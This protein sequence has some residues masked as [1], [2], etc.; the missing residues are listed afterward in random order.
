MGDVLAE[1]EEVLRSKPTK[2]KIT[3]KEEFVLRTCKEKAIGDFTTGALVSSTVVW[4]ATRNLTLGHR[5]NSSIGSAIVAGMWRFNRSLN[6]CINHV[7]E[8]EGSRMQRE[9]AHI[10]LTKHHDNVAK[11]KLVQKHFYSEEVFG[12]LNPDKPYVR[13]RNRNL[14]YDNL[15]AERPK[16]VED[17]HRHEQPAIP[18]KTG[19]PRRKQFNRSSAAGDLIMDPLDCIFGEVEASKDILHPDYGAAV[20]RRHSRAHKRAHR[21]RRAQHAEAEMSSAITDN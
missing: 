6:S 14:Y 2:E 9:L 4:I 8:L 13:W 5:F 12:D 19:I 7:L 20:E 10:I 17:P 3:A 16:D 21:R 18:E 11:M 1:L 15:D